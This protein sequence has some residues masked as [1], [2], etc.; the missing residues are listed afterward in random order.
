MWLDDGEAET[1]S[2]RFLWLSDA[3]LHSPVPPAPLT[4]AFD[5]NGKTAL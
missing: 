1:P 3:Q 2:P 5:R 4:L